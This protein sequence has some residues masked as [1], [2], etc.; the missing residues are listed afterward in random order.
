MVGGTLGG[1]GVLLDHDRIFASGLPSVAG[2]A[3]FA[4][5]WL[6]MVCAMMLPSTALSLGER[7]R[8]SGAG[9]VC[10]CLIGFLCLWE[11]FGLALLVADGL[12]H[13]VLGT[14]PRLSGNAYL[15]AAGILGIVAVWELGFARRSSLRRAPGS[16][17]RPGVTTT[18]AGGFA[19]GAQSVASCGPFMLFMMA[20]S[21]H[22]P[23]TMAAFAALGAYQQRGRLAGQ[24]A[25]VLGFVAL[26]DALVVLA[27][28]TST[29]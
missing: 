21:L 22:D 1:S 16:T 3:G 15:V 5:A 27:L 23:L 26:G 12:L 24:L 25:N 19:L 10:A 28:R 6:V 29:L 13:R 9:D 2:S 11:L 17:A 7:S 20:A 14:N 4:I 8:A 18:L